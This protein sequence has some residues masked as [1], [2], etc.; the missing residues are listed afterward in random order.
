MAKANCEKDYAQGSLASVENSGIQT[1][2]KGELDKETRDVW[3]Q[4][5]VGGTLQRIAWH[6]IKGE[7]SRVPSNM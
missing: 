2:L 1:F 7:A 6:W 3:R 5:W 4:V